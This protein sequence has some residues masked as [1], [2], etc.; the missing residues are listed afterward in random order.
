MNR[1]KTSSPPDSSGRHFISHQRTTRIH[2]ARLLQTSA[3]A[4]GYPQGHHDDKRDEQQ[5]NRTRSSIVPRVDRHEHPLGLD[6]QHRVEQVP[7]RWMRGTRPKQKFELEI[8]IAAALLAA[9]HII[10]GQL[11][12]L[13]FVRR[14]YF[15]R[16]V[17][18]CV[19]DRPTC[20]LGSRLCWELPSTWFVDRIVSGCFSWFLLCSAV[21]LA[22]MVGDCGCLGNASDVCCSCESLL[23][24]QLVPLLT[25]VRAR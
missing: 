3:M 1:K 23:R 2:P 7:T 21:F 10:E 19:V 5:P 8:G 13:K 20:H 11:S 9:L 24:F 25:G 17:A 12:L 15:G 14:L 4:T 22:M 16:V 6:D 18:G